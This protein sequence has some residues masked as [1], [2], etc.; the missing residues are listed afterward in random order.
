MT[1]HLL[2]YIIFAP[3]LGAFILLLIR[4]ENLI[5]IISIL[6]AALTFALSVFL[7]LEFDA[8]KPGFQF[9]EYVPW[10]YSLDAAYHLGIDGI[11]LLLISLTTFLTLIALIA[12]WTSVTK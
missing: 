3:L 8:A 9:V 2:T 1:E 5:K 6:F 4:N 12:S 7:Y 11:S 10:I